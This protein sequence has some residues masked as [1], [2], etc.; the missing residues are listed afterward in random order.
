MFKNGDYV[1]CGNNGICKVED[2]TTLSISGVDKNRQ[3]YLLKPVF[4]SEALSIFL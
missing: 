4:L 2:I 3:Y 1:V